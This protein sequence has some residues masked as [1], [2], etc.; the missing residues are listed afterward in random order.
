[1]LLLQKLIH[2]WRCLAW[3][4][5]LLTQRCVLG[6]VFECSAVQCQFNNSR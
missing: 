6:E 3:E 5:F 1:M 2:E 4:R